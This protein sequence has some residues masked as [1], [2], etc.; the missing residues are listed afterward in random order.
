MTGWAGAVLGGN[1]LLGSGTALCSP[2]THP[3]WLQVVF[4]GCFFSED[5]AEDQ[6]WLTQ[7]L[8]II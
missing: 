3:D 4:S 8:S 1:G 6:F 5:V 7:S 2:Q